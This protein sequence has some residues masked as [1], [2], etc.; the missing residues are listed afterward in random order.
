MNKNSHHIRL[1]SEGLNVISE[2]FAVEIER[3]PIILELM[4]ILTWGLKS[5]HDDVI[6]DVHP[7]NIIE[8]KPKFKSGIKPNNLHFNEKESAIYDL[9]DN[10]FGLATSFFSDLSK[11]IINDTGKSPTLND[12]CDLLVKGLNE[13]TDDILT[14]ISP[15]HIVGI[16]TKILKRQKIST[17]IGDI[18][19]IPARN[20][21]YFIAIVVAK[22]RF[23]TAYGFFEGTSPLR[24]FSKSSHL[25]P[26]RYPIYTSDDLVASERWKKIDHVED[27]LALFPTEP[28]IYH[29]PQIIEG[30]PEIGPYGS[31]ETASGRLRNLSKEEA[32][33]IGLLSGEYDQI[34]LAEFLE[35]SFNSK[36]Q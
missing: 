23:G 18:I 31:G 34:W 35:E 27:L 21:E 20:K 16:K 19:A 1:A 32:E 28:E 36:F 33:E 12:L 2:N 22:N 15:I 11:V 5:C 10:V 30:G 14:D 7:A 9:N 13:C 24:K 6:L 17:K 4:E 3:R 26:K 29:E 8:L 25:I